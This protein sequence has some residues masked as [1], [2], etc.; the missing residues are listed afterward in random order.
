VEGTFPDGD[1]LPSDFLL[2]RT[3]GNGL[4]LIGLATFHASPVWV[5][6]A[7]AD[8]SGAGRQLIREIG[9]SLV[10]DG[11]IEGGTQFD[12]IEQILDGLE[13]TS[14]RLAEA[15][16]TP[17]LNVA[18][19]RAELGA[20]R[21]DARTVAPAPED[22]WHTWYGLEAE[23]AAQD[24]TIWELSSVMALSAV[25]TVA[26]R[27]GS[28]L[29]THYRETLAE[30]HRTGYLRYLARELSPYLRAAVKQFSPRRTSLTQRLLKRWS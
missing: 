13:R 28:T 11:V 22:L 16:N 25:R 20:L 27:T 26:V 18:Q 30:I 3:A 19:L 6:A 23:A 5:L 4:E 10:A 29:L 8:L 1:K 24:R 12:G 9:A 2:R 14:A 17:P 21:D 7:L 15:V